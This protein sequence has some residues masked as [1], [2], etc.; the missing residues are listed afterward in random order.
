MAAFPQPSTS[1][2]HAQ[3]AGDLGMPPDLS[4]LDALEVEL[5]GGVTERSKPGLRGDN[6]QTFKKVS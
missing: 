2:H 1:H 4:Q 6:T 3:P 5:G